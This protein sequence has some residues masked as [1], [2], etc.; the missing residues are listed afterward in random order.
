MYDFACD[1]YDIS[2]ENSIAVLLEFVQTF[3]FYAIGLTQS[4][5]QKSR[6]PLK[7]KYAEFRIQNMLVS[8]TPQLVL[9]LLIASTSKPILSRDFDDTNRHENATN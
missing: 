3:Y 2:D 4:V 8:S 1:N 5:R 9:I 6:Q 7:D